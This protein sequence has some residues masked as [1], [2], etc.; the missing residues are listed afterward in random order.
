MLVDLAKALR[1]S[2]VPCV[3]FVG[4]GGKSTAL[5]QL[6][7]WLR[8][9]V[10]VTSTTHLSTEQAG[11]GDR[12]ILLLNPKDIPSMQELL[13]AGVNVVTGS[14]A[15]RDR[16]SG[17]DEASLEGLHRL[18]DENRL[19]LLI[20]ADGSRQRPL[21]APGEHEPPIPT[22]VE[23][24][25]VVAGMSGLGKP[26]D[27]A[28]VHRPETFA[29]ISTLR[30]GDEITVDAV[31]RVL[32][33]GEGGLKNI[34][35]ESRRVALL[36]QADDPDTQAKASALAGRLLPTYS[37]AVIGSLAGQTDKPE[38]F[39]VHEKISGI[40]L[41]A[42]GSARLGEPKQLLSWHGK[43]FVRHVT[44]TA[45]MAGLDPVV[46]VTGAAHGPVE[47]ALNGLPVSR[48]YNPNWESG[49]S[50][51]VRAG[52]ETLHPEVGAAI[53]LLADQP[54]LP[55]T[56]L[57]SMIE[58]HAST[59]AP[60]IAPLVDGQRGNPVLFDRNTFPELEGLRGD[61]GGRALFS[62]YP[63]TWLQWNDPHA[64]L[65]VDTLEDYQRLLEDS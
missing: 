25:V 37:A 59:L 3:A 58:L 50:S 26:L 43:S 61:T 19:P 41:A 32:L 16:F 42:G 8:P 35:P 1:L 15:E 36:N 23:L 4:A 60:I 24:V 5:F 55:V 54:Q 6:A 17:L 31:S 38:I 13:Q 49:Q 46:V 21:K 30:L 65:D 33:H 11:W 2:S 22:F 51:S 34:S 28:W 20:E 9:P 62:R 27:S 40:V 44:E 7:R 57:R 18:A 14:L 63:I 52:L 10:L 12:H 56:L 45:I 47:A 39:A 64:L 29:S 48:V 53:F